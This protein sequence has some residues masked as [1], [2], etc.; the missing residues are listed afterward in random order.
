L[1]FHNNSSS[2]SSFALIRYSFLLINANG[3]ATLWHDTQQ[4]PLVE[5]GHPVCN[6]KK[7]RKGGHADS[8]FMQTTLPFTYQWWPYLI[9]PHHSKSTYSDV[10]TVI[11]D[12]KG[13]EWNQH[14]PAHSPSIGNL[15][16]IN[17][18]WTPN[19]A[20]VGFHT[21]LAKN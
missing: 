14:P 8:W 18:E 13:L 10:L 1:S 4:H 9:I 3:K 21:Y 11:V 19:Q 5:I 20:I 12:R 17:C 7:K 15:F 2:S 16:R 6:P